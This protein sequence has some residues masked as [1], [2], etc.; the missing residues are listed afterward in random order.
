MVS[1]EDE[2]TLERV[3][4][5]YEAV[6]E[7]GVHRATSIKVAE[8]AKVI[9]NTQ[10]DV[11]I[12][13]MNELALIFDRLEIPF[14]D[15]IRPLTAAAEQGLELTES[16]GDIWHP[17]DEVARLFARHLLRHGYLESVLGPNGCGPGPGSREPVS[18]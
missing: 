16:P 3:A 4:T 14:Y 12:A 11:N 5:T 1:G 13:L 10:R 6:V 2:E 9:E 18:D 7:A 8:A 15:L 17:S